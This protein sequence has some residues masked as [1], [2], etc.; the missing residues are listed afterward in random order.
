MD[1]ALA[2]GTTH[3]RPSCDGKASP[4][5]EPVEKWR[6]VGSSPSP[7]EGVLVVVGWAKTSTQYWAKLKYQRLT[8][9]SGLNGKDRKWFRH[10]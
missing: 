5:T 7:M 10:F 1:P 3:A 8:D 4:F 6:V 9:Q 2:T